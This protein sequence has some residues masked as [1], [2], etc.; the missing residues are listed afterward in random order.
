MLVPCLVL[1]ATVLPTQPDLSETTKKEKEKRKKEAKWASQE[2]V[3]TKTMLH[4][5]SQ[6][7]LFAACLLILHWCSCCLLPILS[8]FDP[9]LNRF[10]LHSLWW[11]AWYIHA[12]NADHESLLYDCNSQANQHLLLN[13]TKTLPQQTRAHTHSLT[14]ATETHAHFAH[15]LTHRETDSERKRER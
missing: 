13:Y 8:L 15:P 3:T 5:M 11:C 14:S 4:D 6:L 1:F 9:G 12:Y 10:E 2:Q 7:S